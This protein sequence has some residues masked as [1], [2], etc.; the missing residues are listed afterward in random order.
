MSVFTEPRTLATQR[1][2]DV[3]SGY[4][5]SDVKTT[6]SKF[7]SRMTNSRRSLHSMAE[8]AFTEGKDVRKLKIEPSFKKLQVKQGNFDLRN[9]LMI[10]R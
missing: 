5:V 1:D 2:Q 10:L 7:L 9:N 3:F 6:S 8:K 4:G